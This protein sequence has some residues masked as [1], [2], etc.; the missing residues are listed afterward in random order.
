MET[1]HDLISLLRRE[2]SIARA[3]AEELREARA[4]NAR[5]LE[6]IRERDDLI[7]EYIETIQSFRSA[8]QVSE[9]AL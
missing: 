5:Y 3:T 8:A 6:A 2:V 7:L 4:E 1:T 9:S